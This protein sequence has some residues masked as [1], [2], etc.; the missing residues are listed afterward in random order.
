[1]SQDDE[2]FDRLSVKQANSD[3]NPSFDADMPFTD[4]ECLT[5]S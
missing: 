5:S 1:M 3:T 4:F 2:H